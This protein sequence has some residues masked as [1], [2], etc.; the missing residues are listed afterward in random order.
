[1]VIF[2]FN[3]PIRMCA[4]A[5]G[6]VRVCMQDIWVNINDKDSNVC[7]SL[8]HYYRSLVSTGCNTNEFAG[9]P[10]LLITGETEKYPE[11]TNKKCTLSGKQKSIQKKIDKKRTYITCLNTPHRRDIHWLWWHKSLMDTK[12]TNDYMLMH[13]LTNNEHLYTENWINRCNN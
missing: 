11:T 8:F 3:C 5:H 12:F 1:M 13:Q 10:H 6:C 7:T 9:M 4:R 2:F